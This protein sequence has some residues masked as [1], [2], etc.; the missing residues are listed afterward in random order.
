MSRNLKIICNECEGPAI[1]TKTHR[2]TALFADLY[3]QC[4][5]AEC[6]H[7]FVLNVTYSHTLSPSARNGRQLVKSLLELLRPE[8]RQMALELLQGSL[9]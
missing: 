9:S 5:D 6:G 7:T 3:C 8:D 2:K 4:K 1:V